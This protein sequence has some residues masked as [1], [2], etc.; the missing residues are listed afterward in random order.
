LQRD[1][2]TYLANYQ[3]QLAEQTGIP[4]LKLGY[5][6]VF[7]YYIEVTHVNT[8]KVPPTFT[9]KQTL[10]N[11]ERYVTPQLKEYEDKVLGAESK[12]IA[13]EQEL[14]EQ[15]CKQAAARL[16]ELHEY[17]QVIAELDVL[18]CFARRAVRFRYVRPTIAA[19]P[20]LHI[21][22]GRHPVLDEILAD[23]FVPN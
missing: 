15:L 19:E 14:F 6:R 16:G 13:R 18:A 17:A 20:V 22:D 11:A 2:S 4:S 7:G 12:A 21:V 1:S 9:R 8:A 3:K 5:N 10:K 23:R